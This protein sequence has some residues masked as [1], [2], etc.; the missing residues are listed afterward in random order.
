MG[1]RESFLGGVLVDLGE[2]DS[3]DFTNTALENINLIFSLHYLRLSV[4]I[5][6]F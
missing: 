5:Q 2:E 1:L 6:C 4:I 3:K